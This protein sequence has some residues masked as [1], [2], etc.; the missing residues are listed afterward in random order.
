MGIFRPTL[1]LP[2][3]IESHLTPLQLEAVLQHEMAHIHRRDNLTGLIHRAVEVLFWFHPLVWWIGA[4]LVEARE[5][6]CDEAVLRSG[7]EPEAY[8]EGILKICELYLT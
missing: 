2:Q 1:L 4:R 5:R 3:G 6:A 8:G 7:I